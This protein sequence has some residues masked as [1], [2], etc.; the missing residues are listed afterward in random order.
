MLQFTNCMKKSMQ[1]GCMVFKRNVGVTSIKQSF[2]RLWS[3]DIFCCCNMILIS[4]NT[5]LCHFC[6]T[7][8]LF[9]SRS[10]LHS[11]ICSF[12]S[13]VSFCVDNITSGDIWLGSYSSYS[14][15]LLSFMQVQWSFVTAFKYFAEMPSE[16]WWTVEL[17]CQTFFQLLACS[18][19]MCWNNAE[20]FFV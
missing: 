6:S 1:W 9:T 16:F 4:S 14:L 20:W 19:K 15:M 3:C 2:N 8:F 18:D 17:C 11:C 10:E 12:S 7:C 5:V 13:S